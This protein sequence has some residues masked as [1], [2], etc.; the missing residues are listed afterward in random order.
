MDLINSN[1]FK[2][3]ATSIDSSDDDEKEF[4][5]PKILGKF[6]GETEDVFVEEEEEDTCLVASSKKKVSAGASASKT[7]RS[8]KQVKAV[9]STGGKPPKRGRKAAAAADDDD[10][11]D[12]H[13]GNASSDD[14]EAGSK[15]SGSGAKAKGKKASQKK[16]IDSKRKD[17]EIDAS[18]LYKILSSIEGISETD[19]SNIQTWFSEIIKQQQT[20]S[21][22]S[23]TFSL[24]YDAI[25][26]YLI[27][28]TR[29]KIDDDEKFFKRFIDNITTFSS[30]N[31]PYE[32]CGVTFLSPLFEAERIGDIK[33]IDRRRTGPALKKGVVKCRKCKSK[34]TQTEPKQDR[35]G[36]EPMSFYHDCRMC[37][38]HW[39][40][41]G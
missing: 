26:S 14:D 5:V 31:S 3:T 23:L 28:K 9:L 22:L 21:S 8:N 2:K 15:T 20:S 33:D 17:D 13:D 36:D 19:A 27:E 32:A 1:R 6:N 35:S 37:G 40:T 11:S 16:Q 10:N 7:T 12:D 30:G 29:G 39:K 18:E 24:A 41:S 34:Y 25:G 38:E 4:A